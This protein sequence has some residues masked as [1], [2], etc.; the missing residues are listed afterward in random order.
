M[1]LFKAVSR[2]FFLVSHMQRHAAEAAQQA[3][4]EVYAAARS[5]N[6]KTYHCNPPVNLAAVIRTT[7]G[8]T[9]KSFPLPGGFTIGAAGLGKGLGL[10][11]SLSYPTCRRAKYDAILKGYWLELRA[12]GRH[13]LEITSFIFVVAGRVGKGAIPLTLSPSQRQMFDGYRSAASKPDEV[14]KFRRPIAL[15][16]QIDRTNGT[17]SDMFAIPTG[18]SVGRE[19]RG[20]GLGLCKRPVSPAC[21]SMRYAPRLNGFWLELRAKNKLGLEFSSFVLVQTSKAGKDAIR[22]TLTQ[23]QYQK[24]AAAIKT[25]QSE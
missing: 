5:L 2:E 12:K 19:G 7:L 15:D 21:Y 3:M 1:Q 22:L 4:G 13:D 10:G 11:K 18:R 8:C 20:R 25:R 17:A 6:G 14:V 24:S 9:Q 16:D 23:G